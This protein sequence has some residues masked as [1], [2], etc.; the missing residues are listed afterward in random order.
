MKSQKRLIP[1]VLIAALVF[2]WTGSG[3]AGKLQ[4]QISAESTVEQVLKRGVLR[5]GMSTW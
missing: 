5:V 4:Q 3:V 2:A 1:I